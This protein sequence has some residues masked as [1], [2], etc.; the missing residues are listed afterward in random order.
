M[1]F[2]ERREEEEEEEEDIMYQDLVFMTNRTV[3]PSAPTPTSRLYC[4]W[5]TDMCRC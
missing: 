4:S 3:A 5:H 2:K 1:V